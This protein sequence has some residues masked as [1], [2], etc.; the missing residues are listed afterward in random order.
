VNRV[1]NICKK[2]LNSF[3][4]T[5]G[6]GWRYVLPT[7]PGFSILEWKECR[8]NFRIDL[9][10]SYELRTNYLHNFFLKLLLREREGG[11]CKAVR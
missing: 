5:R 1:L 9:G 7:Y 10:N 6:R 11:R 3:D 4:L 8:T 2:I